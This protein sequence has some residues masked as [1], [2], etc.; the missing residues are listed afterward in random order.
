M[1]LSLQFVDRT[2]RRLHPLCRDCLDFQSISPQLRSHKLL[3][4]H[5]FQEILNIYSGVQQVDKFLNYLRLKGRNCLNQLIECLQ[6]SLKYCAGHQHLLNELKKQVNQAD[7][8]LENGNPQD[9]AQ[10]RLV[11]SQSRN[12]RIKHYGLLVKQWLISGKTYLTLMLS[13]LLCDVSTNPNKVEGTDS[14]MISLISYM[15]WKYAYT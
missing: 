5:E 4:D 12:R 13:E 8:I 3:T 11:M 6:S 9:P 2:L 14:S 10:V 15:Y 1:N 7:T